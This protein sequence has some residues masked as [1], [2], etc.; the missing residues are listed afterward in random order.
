[1]VA[2]KASTIVIIIGILFIWFYKQP[3]FQSMMDTFYHMINMK[4]IQHNMKIDY[5]SIDT[6]HWNEIYNQKDLNI[7]QEIAINKLKSFMSNYTLTNPRY[8]LVIQHNNQSFI[9][10]HWKILQ[11]WNPTYFKYGPKIQR[12]DKYIL[13]HIHVF[14]IHVMHQIQ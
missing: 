1:M 13:N 10:K 9:S 8:P 11:K 14:H 4:L 5:L 6:V 7:P 3:K 12:N 2:V